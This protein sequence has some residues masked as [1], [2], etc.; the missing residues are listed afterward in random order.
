MGAFEKLF[1]YLKDRKTLRSYFKMLD[2]YAPVFT[3]FDGGV[4]EMELTRSCVHTFAT[5]CSK[6]QP[7]VTGRDKYGY[8]D[9]LTRKPNPFM[10]TAQFL[11]KCATIL[12]TQNTLIIMP[13]LDRAGATVGFYPVDPRVV[14]LVTAS[15]TGDCYVRV[16]FTDGHKGAIELDRC[17]ILNKFLY[18]SDLFGESNRALDPTMQ[19]LHMQNEGIAEGIKHNSSFRFMA[20]VSNFAK[21]ADLKKEREQFV[22][23]NLGAD[24]GG[25]ALFPNTYTNVKQIVSTP[26]VVDP[27]QV[28]L[29]QD[30]VLTYFQTNIHILQNDYDSVQWQAYYEGKVEPFAIQLSQ[31]LTQMCFTSME[32]TRNNEILWSS[33]RL[34]YMSNNDKLQVSS[35]MFD[36]G[37]FSLN[38]VMDIWNLPHVE[39]GEKRYIRR[40]YVEVENLDKELQTSPAPK[41]PDPE[42]DPEPKPEPEPED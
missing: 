19:L 11:Y 1:G 42:P 31:A 38:D 39:N 23:D 3:S 12:E 35:Q 2:G 9:I 30:R 28:H 5:H 16:T 24:S 36:R 34:Q 29:I 13:L 8:H 4:Y 6:L 14:E 40:E 10:T 18:H 21:A 7:N 41:L 22:K 32:Q 33:N 25:L 17:G 26:R 20:N 15:E 27:D 37:V